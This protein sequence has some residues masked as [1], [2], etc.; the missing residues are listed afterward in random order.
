MI[1]LK[2]LTEDSRLK[3]NGKTG[4]EWLMLIRDI[5]FDDLIEWADLSQHFKFKD[6]LEIMQKKIR[7]MERG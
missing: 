4:D 2:Y 3:F 5:P 6:V 7:N 1:K